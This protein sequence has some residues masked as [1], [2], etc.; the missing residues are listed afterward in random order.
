MCSISA[1]ARGKTMFARLAGCVPDFFA[2]PLRAQTFNPR[3]S[4]GAG[5]Q[6][7]YQHVEPSGGTDLNQFSLGPRPYLFR[8]DITPNISVM[9]NTDYNSVTNNLEHTGRGGEFHM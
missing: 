2:S 5:I 3:S 8:R 1:N 7:S 6:T 9:F 4:V